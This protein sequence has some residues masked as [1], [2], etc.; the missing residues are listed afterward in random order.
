[1]KQI[2]YTE[3]KEKC[4]EIANS[5]DNRRKNEEV[6]K[7]YDR[8]IFLSD[9]A[10][11]EGLLELEEQSEA[12]E[13]KNDTDKYLKMLMM[14]IVDG[15]EP[16]MVEEAGINTVIASCIDSYDG[17]ITLMYLYGV[18]M[19]Q[20]GQNTRVIGE[21][22]KTIVPAKIRD[23][24]ESREDL[25]E[26]EVSENTTASNLVVSY[27]DENDR[28]DPNDYSVSGQLSLLLIRL[29]DRSVQRL[30]RDLDY[31]D[32]TYAMKGM[33]GQA[34]KRIF[35]NMSSRLGEMLAVDMDLMGPV[36]ITEAQD[37]AATI[38]KKY[39][40]CVDMCE[41]IDEDV[42]RIKLLIG[43]Y[44]AAKEQNKDIM[45]KYNDLKSIIDDYLCRA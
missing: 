22:M 28:P 35:D 4:R 13:I 9:I 34:R 42:E 8:I 32:I 19:I 37:R 18:L 36:R 40:E 17:L 26:D 16:D 12:I 25:P 23:L 41:I 21:L 1:M 15:T 5:R 2:F 14:L 30:L 39:I 45:C 6:I 24:M 10:R 7:A 20:Q 44:E 33:N 29:D 31:S 27:T 43:M 11:R 38:L 3:L